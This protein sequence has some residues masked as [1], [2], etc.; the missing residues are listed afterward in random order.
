[1]IRTTLLA[2]TTTALMAQAPAAPPGTLAPPP[3]AAAAPSAPAAATSLVERYR[4]GLLALAV[5]RRPELP[6]ADRH[7]LYL[8]EQR[9]VAAGPGDQALAL[10]ELDEV[11]RLVNLVREPAED[12]RCRGHLQL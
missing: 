11:V 6:S 12:Q 7:R 8:D 4:S 9:P 5:Q 2:L 3:G 10:P 1:M